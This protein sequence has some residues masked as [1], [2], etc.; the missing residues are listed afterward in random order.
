MGEKLV[1]L[2]L[3]ANAS[4][5]PNDADTAEQRNCFVYCFLPLGIFLPDSSILCCEVIYEFELIKHSMLSLG[6]ITRYIETPSS[7]QIFF[8]QHLMLAQSSIITEP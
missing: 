2:L 5:L 7:G 3:E 8:Y 1:S 6:Y 4:R